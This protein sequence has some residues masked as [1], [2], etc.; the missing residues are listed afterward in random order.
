MTFVPDASMPGA[1]SKT[2]GI[3]CSLFS[4][5]FRQARDDFVPLYFFSLVLGERLV[6]QDKTR[7][8]FLPALQ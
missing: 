7:F 8:A 3:E 2:A 1:L 5:A 6:R 4:D